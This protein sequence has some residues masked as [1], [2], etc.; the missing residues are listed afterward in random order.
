[1]DIEQCKCGKYQKGQGID[2]CYA[3][4]KRDFQALQKTVKKPKKPFNRK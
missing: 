2:T 1:M 4:E 3:C